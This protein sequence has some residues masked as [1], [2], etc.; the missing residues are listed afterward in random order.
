[1][2]NSL[3]NNILFLPLFFISFFCTALSAQ[4]VDDR[5]GVKGLWDPVFPPSFHKGLYKG[6]MDITKYHL[7]GLFFIKRIS[8]SSFRVLFS[9]EVGMKFFDLECSPDQF[10]VHYCYPS[11][12]RKIVID[13]LEKDLRVLFFNS[14]GI[15]KSSVCIDSA[16]HQTMYKIKDRS[17][18]WYYSVNDEKKITAI[19]SKCKILKKTCL[20]LDNYLS[21]FPS[22]IFLQNKTIKLVINIKRIGD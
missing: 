15:Q 3:S 9:N 14:P 21:G 4:T 13:L 16:S 12:N 19:R 7:S 20:I 8:D 6:S 22:I 18:V 11:L 17:G 1:M 10:T 2:K 5:S